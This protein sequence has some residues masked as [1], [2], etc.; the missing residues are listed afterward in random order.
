MHFLKIS[1]DD[2]TIDA[3]KLSNTVIAEYDVPTLLI[4]KPTIGYDAEP[5]LSTSEPQ[6]YL[7]KTYP[8]VCLPSPSDSAK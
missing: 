5:I 2:L 6:P 7:P 3:S 4:T 1:N 8:N